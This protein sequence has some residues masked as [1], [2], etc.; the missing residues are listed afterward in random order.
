GAANAAE[1]CG[2]EPEGASLEEQGLGWTNRFRTGKGADAITSGLEGAWTSNPVKWD[3]G[4][5]ENLVGYEGELTKRPRGAVQWK[6]KGGGARPRPNSPPPRQKRP[7]R[8]GP[9]GP[10]PGGGPASPCR[11]QS[12]S[13]SPRTSSPGPSPGPGTSCRPATGGRSRGCSARWSP[14]RSCGR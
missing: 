7:P 10:P 8:R 1:Y 13:T 14:R 4:Y 6:P 3:N 9:R 12:A 5:F 2:P 11:P